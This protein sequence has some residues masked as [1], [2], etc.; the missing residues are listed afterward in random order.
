MVKD[1]S[2][3]STEV[4]QISSRVGCGNF[5]GMLTLVQGVIFQISISPSQNGMGGLKFLDFLILK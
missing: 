4:A 2:M 1:F 3:A 5:F